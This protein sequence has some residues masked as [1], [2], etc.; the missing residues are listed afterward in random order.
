MHAGVLMDAEDEGLGRSG[1]DTENA[2][3]DVDPYVVA[4]ETG[5]GP[6]VS[7]GVDGDEVAAASTGAAGAVDG[8]GEDEFY[9]WTQGMWY[10]EVPTVPGQGSEENERRVRRR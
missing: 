2:V 7:G 8:Y 6:A 4:E 3:I 9:D 1:S 5:D 10:R